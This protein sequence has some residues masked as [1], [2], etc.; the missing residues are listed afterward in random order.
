MTDGIK[1]CVVGA[2]SSYTPEL[3]AGLIERPEDSLPVAELRLTDIDPDRLGIMAGLSARMFDAAGRRVTVNSDTCLEAMLEGADFV[4]TTVRVGGMKAR[5]LDES[6]PP[7]YGIIGQETTGPGG[8]FKA[9]RTIPVMLDIAA[10]IVEVCPD[11]LVLNYTN[12][13]GIIAEALTRHTPARIVGL[14]SGIPGIIARLRE[15]LADRYPDLKAYCVGLNHFGFVHR[16][17]SGG[18]DVTDEALEFLYPGA[19]GAECVERLLRAIPISY[20]NYYVRRS[21]RFREV[22]GQPLT[23]AKQIEEIEREVFAE[24]ADPRSASKPAALRKRGGGGYAGITFSV[25][26]AVLHDTGAELAA[27]VPNRG[28]VEGIDDEAVVEVVCRVDAGGATPLPVGPV[29]L[30]FRG[31]VHSIKAYETLTVAAA[32]ERRRD[33]AVLALMNHPLAGDLDVIEP[34]IDEMAAAHGIDL[35]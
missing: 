14:C 35:A 17:V 5:H 6:I 33:L 7:K 3:V 29:P 28:A 16:L 25:M 32:V 34:L 27:N 4:V 15:K 30:A 18:Q 12:P 24:A 13:S 1:V 19:P 10:R 21:R 31:L 23:R 9:L 26:E 22:T 2:G 20:V 8:M 11:A